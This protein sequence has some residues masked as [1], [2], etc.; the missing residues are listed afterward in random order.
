MAPVAKTRSMGV[1]AV[2]II[3]T[4]RMWPKPIIGHLSVTDIHNHKLRALRRAYRMCVGGH[5]FSLSGG[6]AADSSGRQAPVA[7]EHKAS[8]SGRTLRLP[9]LAANSILCRALESRAEYKG[10][11]IHRR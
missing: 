9:A 1:T 11:A 10:Q 7:S 5:R 2:A 8:L 3:A 6:L 4:F